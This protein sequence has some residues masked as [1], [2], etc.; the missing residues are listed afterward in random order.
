MNDPIITTCQWIG[1]SPNLEPSCC[2]PV[3]DGKSYCEDHVWSVYK[4]GTALRKRKK[5]QR[6]A[7]AIWDVESAFNDAVAELVNEGQIEI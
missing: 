3:V 2:K 1:H 6:R 4:E 7:T 5:D